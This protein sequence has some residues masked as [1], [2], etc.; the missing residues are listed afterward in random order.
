MYIDDIYSTQPFVNPPADISYILTAVSWFVTQLPD[1]MFVKV[2]NDLYIPNAFTPDGNGT[3]DTW[4]I[5]A[6]E[7]YPGFRTFYF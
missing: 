1:T 7:A 6:L 2:Y 3:N 4:N 5:S